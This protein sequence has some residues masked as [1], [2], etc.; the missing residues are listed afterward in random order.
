MTEGHRRGLLLVAAAGTVWSLGGLLFRLIGADV[1]TIMC[2]RAL[3]AGLLLLVVLTM[4]TRE[5][6][7]RAIL[8]L[9]WP[10]FF[11]A[12]FFAADSTCYMAAL[13]FTTVA[14]VVV[15][16]S[17]T[18]L[19][20]ALAAWVAMR[21]AIRLPVTIAMFLAFAG[22]ALMVSD[23]Y[24]SGAWIGDILALGVPTLFAMVTVITRRHPGVDLLPA[25]CLAAI[26][27]GL[28]FLP[29]SHLGEA[30]AR[31]LGLMTILGLIEFGLGLL[32]YLAGAKL[33]PSAEA[34]LM[35]L[36]ETVLAPL[37]VWLAV[38]EDPGWRAIAGGVVVLA[39][40]SG[41]ALADMR[42]GA[43]A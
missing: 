31:D 36:L 24:A 42:R 20:A 27:C 13:H 17:L 28:V 39:A 29:F 22:V 19:F 11:V 37:W 5:R 8:G 41:L 3:A 43:A 30:T 14:H 38:A 33:L 1:V 16:L 10:G 21:E 2:G 4:K 34:A 15:M 32:L 9:G 18:P 7:W 12:A 6:P 26:L 23:N 40:L 25:V 35:S